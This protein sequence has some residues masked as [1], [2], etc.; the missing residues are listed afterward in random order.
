M[1]NQARETVAP[2]SSLITKH[3]VDS[4]FH[5]AWCIV[6]GAVELSALDH[7]IA[8]T[9]RTPKWVEKCMALRNLA[10][11]TVGLKN[12]GPLSAPPQKPASEYQKGDRIGIFTLIE[13][14]F[15]EVLLGDSDKHLDVFLSV[16]CRLLSSGKEVEVT[17][18]T[19]VHVHN[20]L[21]RFYMLPVKPL[22][23]VIAPTVLGMIGKTDHL[24]R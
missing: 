5:D 3:L 20:A 23:R 6:S 4:D 15:N 13:N 11:T 14:T 19:V 12:L 18:T 17:I 16:H 21:G 1:K 2:T 7:F 8:A 10:A 22:H 9:A 24:A